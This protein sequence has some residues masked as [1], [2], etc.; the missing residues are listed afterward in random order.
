MGNCLCIKCCDH[1]TVTVTDP[2]LRTSSRAGSTS[3]EISTVPDNSASNGSR[4]SA[5][6]AQHCSNGAFSDQPA[7][8][9][10]NEPE[11]APDSA[12]SSDPLTPAEEES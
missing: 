5:G 8:D 7:T 2:S 1:R 3:S 12:G 6:H 9:E 11:S 10:E 4:I